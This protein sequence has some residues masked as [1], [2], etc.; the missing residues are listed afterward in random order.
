MQTIEWSGKLCLTLLYMF[1]FNVDWLNSLNEKKQQNSDGARSF[2]GMSMK[3]NFVGCTLSPF[4]FFLLCYTQLT[5]LGLYLTFGDLIA[6]VVFCMPWTTNNTHRNHWISTRF[7]RCHRLW[8]DS[9]T[10][11]CS[12]HL[13]HIVCTVM[14]LLLVLFFL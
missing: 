3:A 6:I 14:L 9:C 2:C 8:N 7:Q 5:Q 13:G 10:L 4:L 1:C 11:K 12:T